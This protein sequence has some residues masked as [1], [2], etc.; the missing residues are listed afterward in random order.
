[1]TQTESSPDPLRKI[2][3]YHPGMFRIDGKR[4]K[5]PA[6]SITGAACQLGCSHCKGRLLETMIPAIDPEELVARSKKIAERGDIGILISGGSSRAGTL[7]WDRFVPAIERIKA[8]TSLHV[9]VHGG[10]LTEEIAHGMKS[11]GVDRV[12]VDIVGDDETYAEVFHI[13]DGTRK[14]RETLSA[15]ESAGLSYGPHLIIGVRF[16]GIS[17]EYHGLTLLR[18]FSPDML[19]LVV[20]MPLSKTPMANVSPPALSDLEP[21]F[22]AAREQFPGIPLSLGCAR[23]RNDPALERIALDCGVD[24][25]AIPHEDTVAHAKNL[26]MEI[27]Y[28]PSCCCV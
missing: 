9:S 21:V 15:L 24:R 22:R 11:A 5:Y 23:S 25:M 8:E 2:T 17:G 12:L 18:E 13:Q 4:G 16:G 20:F 10:F 7:P 27:D 3:F 14:L 1:M 28:I 6:I 26:G 19:V